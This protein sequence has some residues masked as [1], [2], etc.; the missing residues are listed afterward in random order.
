M[1]L[2]ESKMITLNGKAKEIVS[3]IME[4][5]LPNEILTVNIK[6]NKLLP[7]VKKNG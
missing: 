1:K 5:Y 2:E 7:E 6:K 4:E 3:Y